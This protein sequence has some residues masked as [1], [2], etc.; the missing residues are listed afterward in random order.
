MDLMTVP[1]Q[2]K[3]GVETTWCVDTK[4]L[5]KYYRS[6]GNEFHP[7]GE[8]AA[9]MRMYANI[10]R[11]MV[12]RIG[13]DPGVVEI[14]TKPVNSWKQFKKAYETISDECRRFNLIPRVEEDAGGDGHIHVSG[15]TEPERV[16]L[17][18]DATR[19]PYLSWAFIHPY[20][21][22]NAK[23]L[24]RWRASG[25]G[26]GAGYPTWKEYA[27]CHRNEYG[28]EEFRLFWTPNNWQEQMEHMALVQAY[29]GKVRKEV[30][31]GNQ[32]QELPNATEAKKLL[33]AYKRS[34]ARCEREFREFI[35]WI[36][37]ETP[38]YAKNVRRM[39]ER[40]TEYPKHLY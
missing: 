9:Y 38:H 14:P 12:T 2:F 30:A 37:L 7:C 6:N 10:P 39:K 21:N 20:D 17:Y 18:R 19:R 15:L 32:G 8:I 33:T 1:W 36:G 3:A 26:W 5:G 13:Q 40:F 28:T 11:N 25:E 22:N 31:A 4:K 27:I 23:T 35:V 24:L 34:F 29:L 16:Y